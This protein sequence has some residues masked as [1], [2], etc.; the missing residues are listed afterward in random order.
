MGVLILKQNQLKNGAI[1]SD[2]SK[3]KSAFNIKKYWAFEKW[4]CFQ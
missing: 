2:E 3:F 4:K 1:Y